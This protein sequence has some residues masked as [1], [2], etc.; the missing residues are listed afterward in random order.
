MGKDNVKNAELFYIY[1]ISNS[2]NDKL[3]FGQTIDKAV[4]RQAHWASARRGE[5]QLLYRAMRCHG[6]D[7]FSFDIVLTVQ[8]QDTADRMETYFIA[9]GETTDPTRGYNISPGG[10][11]GGNPNPSPATR[12]KIGKNNPNFRRDITPEAVV[13]L[14][15][16]GLPVIRIAEYY[17]VSR[18]CIEKRLDYARFPRPNRRRIREEKLRQAGR[19]DLIEITLDHIKEFYYGQQL[20]ATETGKIMLVTGETVLSFLRANNLPIRDEGV[21]RRKPLEGT[22]VCSVCKQDKPLEDF[23]IHRGLSNG[24]HFRCRICQ[25]EYERNL[26]RNRKQR[27]LT[28][29]AEGVVEPCAAASETRGPEPSLV[30]S[31]PSLPSSSN[32]AAPEL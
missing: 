18:S 14:R 24:R 27:M 32:D 4:R 9:E 28:V 19:G 3:Y 11:T 7:K 12:E 10:R 21:Y 6:L 31:F 30:V 1:C 29:A 13:A 15:K 2:V 26:S 5:D 25:R 8:D 23:G 22:Q 16:Q 17:G 20:S